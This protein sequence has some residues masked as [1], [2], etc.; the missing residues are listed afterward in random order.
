M[1][2]LL[3]SS[4]T[5]CTFIFITVLKTYQ[6]ISIRVK[7]FGNA[8]RQIF[9]QFSL[10]AR[11]ALFKK[12][13]SLTYDQQSMLLTKCFEWTNQEIDLT[14]LIPS[15][16]LP[17]VLYDPTDLIWRKGTPSEAMT[18]RTAPSSDGLLA[19]GTTT[20][21]QNVFGSIND[22]RTN[23]ENGDVEGLMLSHSNNIL[24][25]YYINRKNCAKNKIKASLDI[26]GLPVKRKKKLKVVIM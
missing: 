19:S 14:P 18:G 13:L 20:L 22:N 5:R 7:I 24:F 8:C 26:S 25:A 15:F 17:D 3:F 1:F 21:V 12:Y 2:T 16:S 4:N 23:Q 10:C 9:P 6:M 11:K